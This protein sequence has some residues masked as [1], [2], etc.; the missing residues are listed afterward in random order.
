MKE[1]NSDKCIQNNP[2]QSA[3]L[4]MELNDNMI[5][6]ILNNLP[7]LEQGR[8]FSREEKKRSEK[9]PSIREQLAKKP[10]QNTEEKCLSTKKE[11]ER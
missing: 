5:D 1:H 6:G 11:M 7:D 8:V 2:L 9:K 3:E 4:S 10:E